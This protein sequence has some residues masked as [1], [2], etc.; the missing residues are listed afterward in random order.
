MGHEQFQY[1]FTDSSSRAANSVTWR[2]LN[3]APTH[4][5]VFYCGTRFINLPMGA[6]SGYIVLVITVELHRHIS[7]Y[8]SICGCEDHK[9]K[10]LFT[11]GWLLWPKGSS[12]EPC[13][14]KTPM[15]ICTL[16]NMCT[17]M[18]S[19]THTHARE[20]DGHWLLVYFTLG[21]CP[22]LALAVRT[23]ITS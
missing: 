18:Q 23:V 15:L 10:L 22:L 19:Y 17:Q 20:T 8:I 14:K 2:G 9:A 16:S 21:T 13:L 7:I 3:S 12:Q 5:A 6:S 11:P 4:Y 1:C